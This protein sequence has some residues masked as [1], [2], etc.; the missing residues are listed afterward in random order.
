VISTATNTGFAG[1]TY[2]SDVN[3]KAVEK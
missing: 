3:Y 2:I 1:N